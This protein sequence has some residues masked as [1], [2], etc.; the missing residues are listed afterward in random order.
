[1]IPDWLKAALV[2]PLGFAF[3]ALVGVV[4]LMRGEF[5]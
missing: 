5:R 3:I 1:M 2:T 4:K